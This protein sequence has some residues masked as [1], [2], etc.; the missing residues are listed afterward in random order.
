[1]T[2]HDPTIKESM[3]R[4]E[5]KIDA[6]IASVDALKAEVAETREIVEAWKSVKLWGEFVKWAAGIITA[7][8]VM[9]AAWKGVHK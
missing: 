8:C 2:P 9:F 1:M 3:S 5:Q 6:L 4:M 7:A